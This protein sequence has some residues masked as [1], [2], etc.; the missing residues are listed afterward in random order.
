MD[1]ISLATCTQADKGLFADVKYFQLGQV[2]M[3]KDVY[4][5]FMRALVLIEKDE[6]AKLA[7]EAVVIRKSTTALVN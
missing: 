4:E 6:T 2:N 1:C 5:R 3:P 7:Q